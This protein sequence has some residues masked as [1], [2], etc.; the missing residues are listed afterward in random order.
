MVPIILIPPTLILVALCALLAIYQVFLRRP[1]IGAV[2]LGAG[3]AV[4]LYL[5]VNFPDC[6]YNC[7]IG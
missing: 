7:P 5:A 4:V 2:L 3:L 1:F 6:V